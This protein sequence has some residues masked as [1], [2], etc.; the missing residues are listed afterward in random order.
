MLLNHYFDQSN[1]EIMFNR[2]RDSS[3]EKKKSMVELINQKLTKLKY[4]VRNL[5]GNDNR[6][7]ENKKIIPIFERIL[8]LNKEKTQD[9]D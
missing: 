7:E 3:D 4:I 1:S 5:P 9:M 8:E 6:V 2:L